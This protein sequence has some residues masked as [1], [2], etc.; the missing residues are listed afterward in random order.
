MTVR[1]NSSCQEKENSAYA[2]SKEVKN[3]MKEEVVAAP[4]QER[5]LVERKLPYK[6]EII[7]LGIGAFVTLCFTILDTIK[8]L[9]NS[10]PKKLMHHDHVHVHD[11]DLDH[12]QYHYFDYEQPDYSCQTHDSPCQGENGTQSNCCQNLL[13]VKKNPEWAEGRCYYKK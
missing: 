6:W 5:P 10:E 3:S 4:E 7:V 13:Y 8:I 12:D 1:C 9:P 11:H 2:D